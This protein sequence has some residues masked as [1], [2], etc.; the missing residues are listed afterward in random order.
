M[1]AFILGALLGIGAGAF[2]Y[3]KYGARLEA[4]INTPAGPK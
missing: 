4:F 1:T 2:L 3:R